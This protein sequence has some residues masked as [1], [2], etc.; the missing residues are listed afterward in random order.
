[1]IAEKH[2]NVHLLDLEAAVC[3]DGRCVWNDDQGR[4]LFT[5]AAHFS[6]DGRAVMYPWLEN[7][8]AHALTATADRS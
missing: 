8:I 6:E 2:D 7:K 5:D 1:M 3:P 4:P